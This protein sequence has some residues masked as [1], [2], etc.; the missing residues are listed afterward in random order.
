[1]STLY[2]V[3]GILRFDDL[4]AFNAAVQA[5]KRSKLLTEDE[6]FRTQESA[7]PQTDEG[8]SDIDSV[9]LVIEIPYNTYRNFFHIEEET[10]GRAAEY[11]V[12]W[13]STDGE[14]LGGYETHEE[15]E[16]FNLDRWA[17]ENGFEEVPPDFETDEGFEEYVQWQAEVESAFFEEYG[18]VIPFETQ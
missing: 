15:S 17:T 14:F 9:R 5:F 11:G 8:D 18:A 16:E 6:R 12:V 3:E 10:L 7:M 13:T 4:D 2:T 1:M